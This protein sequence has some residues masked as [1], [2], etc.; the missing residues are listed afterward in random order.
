[1]EVIVKDNKPLISVFTPTYNRAALLSRLYNSLGVQTY[2]NFEWII[3]DDGSYDNTKEVVETFIR[4]GNI[5]IQFVCQQNAGKHRAINN[6][7]QLAKGELFFIVDS[8][9]LLPHTA[10]EVVVDHYKSIEDNNLF[11]GVSGIDG[12]FD[13]QNIGTGLPSEIIDCNSIDIRYKYHVKGDLKEVFRTSVIKE[14]PF[15]EIDGER[16][17]PEALVWNRIAL[18]YK[19]RYFN[20]VIYQVEYLDGGLTSAIIKNRMNSPIASMMCYAEMNQLDIPVKDK[21][22]AAINYWRFRLCYHGNSKRPQLVGIWNLVAPLGWLM[23]LND[24]RVNKD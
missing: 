11:A 2:K 10:L 1:M 18:K 22:K 12:Y 17:C 8:D 19:L 20:S 9:D 16:F 6:G 4:K 14:F 3:V 24:I 23:H 15:P 13:G 7:V 5:N 21:L